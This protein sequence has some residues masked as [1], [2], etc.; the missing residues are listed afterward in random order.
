[1]F[2]EQKSGYECTL[3]ECCSRTCEWF[4]NNVSPD[5][6]S[7][8]TEKRLYDPAKW[9]VVVGSFSSATIVDARDECCSKTCGEVEC[10]QDSKYGL[11]IQDAD[12]RNKT[13]AGPLAVEKDECCEQSCGNYHDCPDGYQNIPGTENRRAGGHDLG[14]FDALETRV[15][16]EEKDEAVKN[17]EK[18]LIAINETIAELKSELEKLQS[19]TT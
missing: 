16:R 9:N 10:S 12:A 6:C 11:W 4:S 17:E 13:L 14:Y 1:V 18:E 8:N 5:F 2:S 15:E 7:E 3:D 19:N